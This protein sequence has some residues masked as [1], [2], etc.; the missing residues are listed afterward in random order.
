MSIRIHNDQAAGITASQTGRTDGAPG[1]G[2]TNSRT[3]QGGTGADR[4]EVSQVAESI[5]TAIS[6]QKLQ[7]ANRVSHLAALYA[8]DRYTPDSTRIS[9]A[10]VANAVGTS[11]AGKA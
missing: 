5:T 3:T 7:Q 8:S 2:L 6:S 1:A 4:V 10:L 9:Q 11:S